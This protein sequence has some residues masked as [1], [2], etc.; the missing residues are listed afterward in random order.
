M[1]ITLSYYD[2]DQ[3]HVVAGG[4]RS[5]SVS[6]AEDIAA[7]DFRL[8]ERCIASLSSKYFTTEGFE[9]QGTNATQILPGDAS[10]RTFF[11][12]AFAGLLHSH[13]RD[14]FGTP[15]SQARVHVPSNIVRHTVLISLAYSDVEEYIGAS[16]RI[17]DDTRMDL[18][19]GASVLS[20]GTD[21][22]AYYDS[23]KHVFTTIG[24]T[25][26]LS[27]EINTVAPQIPAITISLTRVFDTESVS[28]TADT[29]AAAVPQ[30]TWDFVTFV[31]EL[32]HTEGSDVVTF[33]TTD[34]IPANSVAGSVSYFETANAPGQA[35]AHPCIVQLD[36]PSFRAYQ[37]QNQCVSLQSVCVRVSKN[38]HIHSVRSI[39]FLCL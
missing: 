21:R 32:S 25:F 24:D 6:S 7:E 3:L 34:A 26:A 17:G 1:T 30:E 8:Y 31:F 18:F 22:L 39:M 5:L 11:T 14:L 12:G 38:K 36:L 33:D 15:L 19:V 35:F 23:K 29:G 10:E 28:S 9:D 4:A 13:S 16:T 20:R 37:Q 2:N 27:H